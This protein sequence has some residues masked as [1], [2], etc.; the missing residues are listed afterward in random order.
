[1]KL[2]FQ[3][4]TRTAFVKRG[5]G[6]LAHAVWKSLAKTVVELSLLVFSDLSC[7]RIKTRLRHLQAHN[8]RQQ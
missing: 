6:H 2:L 4:F 1:M 3:P 5:F 7:S 8:S